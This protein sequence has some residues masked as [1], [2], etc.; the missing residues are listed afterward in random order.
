M[1]R[2]PTGIFRRS[3]FRTYASAIG[4]EPEQV[5]G[6]FQALYPD[7]NAEEDITEAVAQARNIGLRR[8]PTRLRC[9]IDSAVSAL[10]ALH[11]QPSFRSTPSG[12]R[13]ERVTPVAEPIAEVA[14]LPTWRRETYLNPQT[15]ETQA[16]QVTQETEVTQ[17]TQVA[18][19]TPVAPETNVAHEKSGVDFAAVAQLCTRLARALDVCDVTPVLD[20]AARV[21]RAA[22]L[23]LWVGD[24]HGNELTPVFTH[25]YRTR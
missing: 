19:E 24:R 6:E 9:L 1:S 22:G 14:P 11:L 25:G 10:P 17:E 5:I 23:I 18:Q 7:P 12:V 21:L 15:Q 4:L 8:P 3:Y 20:E 16:T 2:W 13:T